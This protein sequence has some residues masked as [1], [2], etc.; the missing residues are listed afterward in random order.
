MARN[1]YPEI[2]EERILEV[3]ERLFLEKGFEQT[4][5]QDIVDALG[6]LTKGAV[7]HHFKS[8][9][10]IIDAVSDRM[11]LRSNPFA[12][13]AKR[14]D[15][16]G[17]EKIRESIRLNQRDE[18]R[19]A[20]TVQ[21]MPILENPRF[22]AEM[23]KENQKTLVPYLRK[24]IEEGIQDGSI[25]TE[26]PQELAEVMILL[27]GLWMVPDVYPASAEQML[28]KFRFIGELLDNMG[29]PLVDEVMLQELKP[30]F[31]EIEQA[32]QKNT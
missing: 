5:I 12:A 29:L 27:T 10:E 11:F 18:E 24:F 21:S 32:Q 7:Y 2:T 4:T 22:L 6:N 9:E 15:L 30:Y 25:H 17:L 8:K 20:I 13:A 14:S 31:E 3:A 16:N 1:K 23:I 26:Y 19:M 28:R